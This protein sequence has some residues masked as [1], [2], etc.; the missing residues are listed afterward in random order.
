MKEKLKFIIPN[1][2][3]TL[4]FL[5]ALFFP[6]IFLNGYINLAIIIFI[7]AAISD[8]IDGFL[9]RKWKIESKYGQCID[10]IADKLLSGLALLILTITNFSFLLFIFILELIIIII[11]INLYIKRKNIYVTRWGKIKTII[12]FSTI[13]I[14]IIATV[15]NNF[16][17][18]LYLFVII[19]AI[20]QTFTIYSYSINQK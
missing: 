10:P 3:T 20:L 7:V 19:S 12:L 15:N 9:A 11:N 17:F 13:L 14:G 1:I 18:A 16:I 5:L 8:S 6:I 4:R 2:I